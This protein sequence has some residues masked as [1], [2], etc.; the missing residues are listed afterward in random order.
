MVNAHAILQNFMNP[1]DFIF[2]GI[3]A[4]SFFLD[5]RLIPTIQKLPNNDFL[6]AANAPVLPA[7]L[8]FSLEL[9]YQVL[10]LMKT[11]PGQS[12]KLLRIVEI[13]LKIFL[14]LHQV[15]RVLFQFEKFHRLLIRKINLERL[16]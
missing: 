8:I 13:V 15:T 12:P 7:S 3:F 16:V 11:L 2:Q 10:L 4:V 1:L 6:T 5:T 9:V 14:F